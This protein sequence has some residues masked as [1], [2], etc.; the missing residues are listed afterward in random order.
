M[1]QESFDQGLQPLVP[2][3][4]RWGFLKAILIC[5]VA[6]GLLG[7]TIGA[8]LQAIDGAALAALIGGTPLAVIGAIALGFYGFLFGAVN[9]VRHG[10]LLGVALGLFVGGLLGV[11]VGLTIPA[12]PWSP[13]GA[14]AGVIVGPNLVAREQRPLGTFLGAIVGTCGGILFLAYERDQER[15]LAGTTYGVL[16][17]MIVGSG[18]LPALVGSLE[19]MP[20]TPRGFNQEG[21]EPGGSEGDVE[22]DGDD[23]NLP[24][25]PSLRKRR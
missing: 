21:D 16:T 17:G 23:D 13:A 20:R 11:L 3:P 12:F 2:P 25:R 14:V 8:A 15:F 4:G 5:G 7:A 18:L 1:G 24:M 22:D 6:G 19:L 9:R 10:R